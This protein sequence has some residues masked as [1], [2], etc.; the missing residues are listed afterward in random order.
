MRTE[1]TL[2]PPAAPITG[3]VSELTPAADPAAP[4]PP[5]YRDPVVLSAREH[6]HWRLLPGD[7]AFAAASHAVPLVIGEFAAAARDYPLV[8]TGTDAAPV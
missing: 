8:F 5:L 6:A 1:D 4:M 2:H 3:E 7:A